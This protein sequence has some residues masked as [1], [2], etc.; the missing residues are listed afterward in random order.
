MKCTKCGKDVNL[1]MG[2]CTI[3]GEP[4]KMNFKSGCLV[5]IG[6]IV[7]AWLMVSLFT[8]G[9]N[10]PAQSDLKLQASV[11]FT[12]TTFTIQNKDSFDWTNVSLEINSKGFT[13]GYTLK[14]G[15]IE[16]GK[17]YEVGATQFAKSDGEKFNPFTHKP[18]SFT[19]ISNMTNGTGYY[20]GSW[21]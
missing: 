12:G 4:I 18:L 14:V 13:T 16:A 3:C 20:F 11:K 17:I 19:I 7:A 1:L 8:K 15:R 2:K 10:G 5:V 21:E 6:L 9:E